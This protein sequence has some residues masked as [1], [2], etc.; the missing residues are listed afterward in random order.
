MVATIARSAFMTEQD[1]RPVAAR[2]GVSPH[3]TVPSNSL[4]TGRALPAVADS[5]R[6]THLEPRLRRC[7]A[8]F[9]IVLLRGWPDQPPGLALHEV[10]RLPEV[11]AHFGEL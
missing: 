8:A 5:L 1:R 3:A 4:T 2:K 10:A 7:R 9:I 6:V 11:G